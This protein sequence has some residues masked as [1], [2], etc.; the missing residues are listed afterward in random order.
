MK[1]YTEET[2]VETCSSY[3]GSHNP[4]HDDNNTRNFGFDKYDAFVGNKNFLNFAN[5]ATFKNLMKKYVQKI[6]QATKQYDN[7]IYELLNEPPGG[8]QE[9]LREFM[10]TVIGWIREVKPNALISFN[11]NEKNFIKN[12]LPDQPV[13]EKVD[14]F[15]YHALNRVGPNWGWNPQPEYDYSNEQCYNE[16]ASTEIAALSDAHFQ[17]YPHAA[18]I[19]SDDGNVCRYNSTGNPNHLHY[20]VEEAC[21]YGISYDHMDYFYCSPDQGYTCY[22]GGSMTDDWPNCYK[23]NKAEKFCGNTERHYKNKNALYEISTAYDT[24][25]PYTESENSYHQFRDALISELEGPEDQLLLRIDNNSSPAYNDWGDQPTDY[26]LKDLNNADTLYTLT[27]VVD[28]Y[29]CSVPLSELTFQSIFRM[30]TGAKQ[31]EF[32]K[33]YTPLLITPNQG[34]FNVFPTLQIRSASIKAD[35]LYKVSMS[36]NA[37]NLIELG[38]FLGK[39][40][41][42]DATDVYLEIIPGGPDAS[43]EIVEF[44]TVVELFG[45]GYTLP[46]WSALTVEWVRW[47]DSWSGDYRTQHVATTPQGF[48]YI[49]LGLSVNGSSDSNTPFSFSIPRNTSLAW[50]GQELGP[51]SAILNSYP[52]WPDLTAFA[53]RA[54]DGEPPKLVLATDGDL[55]NAQVINYETDDYTFTTDIETLNLMVSRDNLYVLGTHPLEEDYP[56][57]LLPLNHLNALIAL[58]FFPTIHDAYCIP[59]RS[60]TN[61]FSYPDLGWK[62]QLLVTEQSR[63][64]LWYRLT[65]PGIDVDYLLDF[66]QKAILSVPVPYPEPSSQPV[67]STV[68]GLER[69]T[70]GEILIARITTDVTGLDQIYLDY[71]A[72]PQAPTEEIELSHSW[73]GNEPISIQ[74]V[75]AVFIA[76][77]KFLVL[78]ADKVSSTS[79][80][81]ILSRLFY[82]IIDY[83]SSSPVYEA[84]QV[85]VFDYC[86]GSLALPSFIE[87]I[88]IA[89]LDKA[90]YLLTYAYE[91]TSELSNP[92]YFQLDAQRLNIVSYELTPLFES[93]NEPLTALP[94]SSPIV[95]QRFLDPEAIDPLPPP[96]LKQYHAQDLATSA[97]GDFMA[98]YRYTLRCTEDETIKDFD[99]VEFRR[100]QKTGTA[101][102]AYT[103]EP[104][105]TVLSTFDELDQSVVGLERTVST[106]LVDYDTFLVC[107][108]EISP[109][110]GDF[111]IYGRFSCRGDW[112][113]R[114]NMALNEPA[115]GLICT[116]PVVVFANDYYSAT[117]V[118]TDITNP[119]LIASSVVTRRFSLNGKPLSDEIVVN[120][121]EPA[122]FDP[123]IPTTTFLANTDVN[124]QT[125]FLTGEDDAGAV[126]GMAHKLFSTRLNRYVGLGDM[127]VGP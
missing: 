123:S 87:H 99:R 114:E 25:N 93:I 61:V 101:P 108:N 55:H 16:P 77:G 38:L 88:D 76:P 5:N 42:T 23:Q 75:K 45:H 115:P 78:F 118:R 30:V 121:F 40:S 9:L 21:N 94:C 1:T 53:L 34:Y 113:E 82:S 52:Y 124:G 59:F 110:T 97:R 35:Q 109:E 127:V 73:N 69:S 67:S 74:T 51:I 46:C 85:P 122:L 107:W 81:C 49:P 29:E 15:A 92:H 6:V 83:T 106:T 112:L 126:S 84:C 3:W 31:Y 12:Y 63:A 28:H 57:S 66:G 41:L 37:D 64:Y 65:G 11:S 4:L 111:N 79:P 27:K 26:W 13:K 90:N 70:T 80:L 47:R 36:D 72:G 91:R 14:V 7:I 117:W 89:Q 104:A 96:S 60:L 39:I 71:L 103:A 22:F 17:D 120:D 98:A 116:D 48:Q 68:F 18:L 19:V 44:P 33:Y 86:G 119:A 56:F 20:W 100:F 24:Y 10:V 2:A 62:Y 95:E 105:P 43:G 32:G 50:V 102:L 8:D 58:Q 125:V 54:S